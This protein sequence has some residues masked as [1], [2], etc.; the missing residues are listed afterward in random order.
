MPAAKQNLC[1]WEYI[2]HKNTD[3][4]FTLWENL[5]T[6]TYTILDT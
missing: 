4:K 3:I 1:K 5:E 2:S 6:V